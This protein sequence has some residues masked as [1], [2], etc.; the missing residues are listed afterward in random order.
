MSLLGARM[1]S[2]GR[3]LCLL[4]GLRFGRTDIFLA[5]LPLQLFRRLYQSFGGL[6]AALLG[7]FRRLLPLLQMSQRG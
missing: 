6:S 3:M 4:Y 5:E 2:Y 7:G 1:L